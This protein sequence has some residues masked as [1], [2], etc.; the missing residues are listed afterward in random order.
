RMRQLLLVLD[1]QLLA[2]RVK[3]RD[4]RRGERQ[5]RGGLDGRR[6]PRMRLRLR[7]HLARADEYRDVVFLKTK[8]S[9]LDA[10]RKVAAARASS[11]ERPR[12]DIRRRAPRT[13]P[14]GAC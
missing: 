12:R 3:L 1:R 10:A 9:P 11:S 5:R 8:L 2:A 13:V 14:A 4:L 7:G 6:N